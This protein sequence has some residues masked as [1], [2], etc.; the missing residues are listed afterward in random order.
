R[1]AIAT[2]EEPL[3]GL[4]ALEAELDRAGVRGEA[5][6]AGD[7]RGGGPQP[8]QARGIDG[9]DARDLDEVVH[10]ERRGVAAGACRRH[11]VARA[12]GVVAERLRRVLA[13]EDAAGVA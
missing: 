4:L 6:R 9:D 10:P 8:A 11:D 3:R 12:G 7:L 13:D 2:G 1:T 5:L